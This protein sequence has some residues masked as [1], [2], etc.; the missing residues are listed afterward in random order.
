MRDYAGDARPTGRK[1]N[2]SRVAEV[3]RHGATKKPGCWRCLLP[4]PVRG[5]ARKEPLG[6]GAADPW[7][8]QGRQDPEL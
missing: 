6:H 1:G 8:L 2:E 3:P 4:K 7:A 5:G